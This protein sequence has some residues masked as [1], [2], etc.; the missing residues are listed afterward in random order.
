MGVEWPL[1]V[2]HAPGDPAEL[3]GEGCSQLVLVHSLRGLIEP[4]P[5]AETLPI[6]RSHQDDVRH[7]DEQR[8]EMPTAALRDAA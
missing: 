6:V 3:V 7:L 1:V 4:D 2:E 8:A 5:E